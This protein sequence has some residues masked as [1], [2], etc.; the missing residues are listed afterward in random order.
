MNISVR[1]NTYL[2]PAM[3]YVETCVQLF[4]T[5]NITLLVF[6]I[7]PCITVTEYSKI[8]EEYSASIVMACYEGKGSVFL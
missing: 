6:H 2:F 5:V 3:Y 1:Y 4:T 8:S 7:V